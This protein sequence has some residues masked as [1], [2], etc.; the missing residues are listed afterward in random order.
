MHYFV[1]NNFEHALVFTEQVLYKRMIIDINIVITN[2]YK[3]M[4][5]NT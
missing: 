3:A 1:W 4:N 5:F 2:S